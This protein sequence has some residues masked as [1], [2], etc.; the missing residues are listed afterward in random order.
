MVEPPL[1]TSGTGR[2]GLLA[3]VLLLLGGLLVLAFRLGGQT[4]PGQL[5]T[6]ARWQQQQLVN[7]AVAESQTLHSDWLTLQRFYATPA[8]GALEAVQRQAQLQR[9]HTRH[10]H[11]SAPTEPACRAVQ[12]AVSALRETTGL[13][14]EGAVI[15][16]QALEAARLAINALLGGP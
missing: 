6:P 12:A 7:R 9:I 4:V 3:S 11:C 16:G 5:L 2:R 8:T 1:P 13:D 15:V 14:P 10:A